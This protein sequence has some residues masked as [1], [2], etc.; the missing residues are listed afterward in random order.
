MNDV[1]DTE[2]KLGTLIGY[3]IEHNREHEEEF[4]DWAQKV[5]AT[6]AQVT[7]MLLKAAGGLAEATTWLEKAGQQL[8]VE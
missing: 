1:E 3:W 8:D 5:S 6:R 4:R 7:A 2:K